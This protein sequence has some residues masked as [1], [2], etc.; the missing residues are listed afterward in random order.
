M[1]MAANK[2]TN[3][4]IPKLAI[5]TQKELLATPGVVL[6]FEKLPFYVK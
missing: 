6:V 5:N 1:P 2:Q 3:A 4:D